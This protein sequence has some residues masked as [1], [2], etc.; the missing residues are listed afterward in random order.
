MND[1]HWAGGVR[2]DAFP[3]RLRQ[4]AEQRAEPPCADDQQIGSGGGL[5]QDV[6]GRAAHNPRDDAA[7]GIESLRDGEA[8]RFAG[9]TG[10]V[11]FGRAELGAVEGQLPTDH[12]FD[13]ASGELCPSRCPAQRVDRRGRT[14][15]PYHD[16]R[17]AGSS[18][19]SLHLNA[20]RPGDWS[21]LARG[22]LRPVV[23]SFHLRVLSC[24]ASG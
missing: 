19:D 13:R 17:R 12:R 8:Q 15:H 9:G 7:A 3:H 20:R 24:G 22:H 11:D 5:E 21:L 14:V 1:D 18:C 4:D 2:D 16:P 10:P 6:H 23:A